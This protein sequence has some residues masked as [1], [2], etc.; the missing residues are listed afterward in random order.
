MSAEH[1]FFH[2]EAL[3]EL[4][5]AIAW[6]AQRSSRA[7]ERFLAEVKA[8]ARTI[9]RYPYRPPEFEAGSRRL[10]LR[11]FPYSVVY[12]TRTDGIEILA[13]AHGRRR[14]GYWRVRM[15]DELTH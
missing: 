9:S 2:P 3:E 14:P 6:Y 13:V 10:R 4:D 15:G 1:V 8:V 11:T 5:S 12:A 7:A